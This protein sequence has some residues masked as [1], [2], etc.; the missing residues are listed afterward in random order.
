LL[1]EAP[2]P[3]LGDGKPRSDATA[4]I[5][6]P[7][8]TIL[9]AG[10][11]GRGIGGSLSP[12]MHNAEGARLGLR[13]AYR[14]YDFDVLGLA[15]SELPWFIANAR[16]EGYAGLNITHPFKERVVVCL[17]DLT[18]D[19][20]AIGAVNTIVFEGN[21][22]VGH[23]TDSWGFAESFRSSMGGAGL[24]CA[25]LLGAGGAGKAVA[26]ALVE[27]GAGRIDIFDV[28]A[29]R[30][31]ALA[32]AVN[33]HPGGPP[34]S[35]ISD[36]EAAARQA[37]GVV[38]ATPLGM[39]KYPGMPVPPEALRPDLWV[40]DIVYFP[41]ETALLRAAASAG[42]RTL[43]G[44]G[45]AVLQAVKAFELITRRSPDRAAMYRH[46]ESA[47]NIASGDD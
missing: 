2:R 47:P 25:L 33:A 40:A 7:A 28:D 13:Y 39:A 18:P 16:D 5:E 38:N 31:E 14:L 3:N 15:D 9:S 12:R 17:D 45:M 32:A 6:L 42:S 22:S 37:S 44:K 29:A 34:A 20:A 19:A 27:L 26:Q 41:A 8:D 1:V 4:V 23:N 21:R 46:F 11:L 35:A 43:P 30:S 24:D 36:V 10:L